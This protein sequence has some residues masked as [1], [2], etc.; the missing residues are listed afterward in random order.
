[1]KAFLCLGANMSD[2]REHIEIALQLLDSDPRIKVLRKSSL[3]LCK[4]YGVTEQADFWNQVV[5]V[6]TDYSPHV[7]LEKSLRNES[8][9]GRRRGPV[10]WGPRLIDIDI[11]LCEDAIIESEDLILPHPDFHRRQFALSLMC[12]LEP[13]LMHPTLNKS[14]STLLQDLETSE[15][16]T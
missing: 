12:E 7:L 11:L 10:K 4:A 6:E 16:L 14:M 15:E 3:I 2:P 1:M 5:E 9:L 13:D 8:K